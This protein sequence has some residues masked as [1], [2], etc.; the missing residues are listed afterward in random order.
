MIGWPTKSFLVICCLQ[1][2][3]HHV[4]SFG[5]SHWNHDRPLEHSASSWPHRDLTFN[6]NGIEWG[7]SKS[8]AVSS[9]PDTKSSS[10]PVSKAPIHPLAVNSAFHLID[11]PQDLM[12][13]AWDKKQSCKKCKYCGCK[14]CKCKKCKKKKKK[15]KKCGCKKCKKCEKCK[16]GGKKKKDYW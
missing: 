15:C 7:Q 14:K 8:R 5:T 1:L 12:T 4:Q 11:S 9:K 2:F 6:R 13:A 16:C 3:A 10:P